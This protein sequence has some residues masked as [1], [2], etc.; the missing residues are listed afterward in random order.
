MHLFVYW[1]T[2]CLCT[3]CYSGRLFSKARLEKQ[4]LFPLEISWLSFFNLHSW[5]PNFGFFKY[6]CFFRMCFVQWVLRWFRFS[7]Q[8][9]LQDIAKS[10]GLGESIE[11]RLC[12]EQKESSGT[13]VFMINKDFLVNIEMP[14]NLSG[15]NKLQGITPRFF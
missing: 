7:S 11:I 3:T 2:I 13:S 5:K 8:G 9:G 1:Y 14:T 4:S 6:S 12:R 10:L 15:I